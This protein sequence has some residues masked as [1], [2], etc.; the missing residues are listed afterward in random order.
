VTDTN[1]VKHRDQIAQLM[2][3]SQIEQAQRLSS[4]KMYA[5]AG[6]GSPLSVGNQLGSPRPQLLSFR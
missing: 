1:Q 6:V 4:E 5:F 3:P 2:A